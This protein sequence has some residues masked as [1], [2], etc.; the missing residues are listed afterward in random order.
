[1]KLTNVSGSWTGDFTEGGGD[2]WFGAGGNGTNNPSDTFVTGSQFSLIAYVGLNPYVD[3]STN[4]WGT[5]FFPQP[6]GSNGYWFLGTNEVFTSTRAGEL[7]FG[8]NDDARS[9]KI[10]DNFGAL[11]GEIITNGP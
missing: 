5:T 2:E 8:F 7:W 10:I 6:S 4:E 9:E 1:V 11:S 3:G